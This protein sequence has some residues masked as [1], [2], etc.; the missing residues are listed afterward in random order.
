M[1]TPAPPDAQLLFCHACSRRFRVADASGALSCPA[2]NS[3]F[4]EI[5]EDGGDQADAGIRLGPDGMSE[6]SAEHF[7]GTLRTVLEGLGGG[8]ATPMHV[9]T[10]TGVPFVGCAV[11][12]ADLDAHPCSRTTQA[13]GSQGTR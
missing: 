4:V 11:R 8:A 12:C 5:L 13:S 2:C 6:Q 9:N 7:L 10:V 3:D 1:T